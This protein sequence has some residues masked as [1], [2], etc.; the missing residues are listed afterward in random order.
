MESEKNF[1]QYSLKKGGWG[2]RR[3]ERRREKER[4]GKKRKGMFSMLEIPPRD[5]IIFAKVDID[6]PTFLHG[7]LIIISS[8][9][10]LFYFLR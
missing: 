9:F 5:S 7:L 1:K 6:V 8:N 4:K 3:Q 10:Y 2:K